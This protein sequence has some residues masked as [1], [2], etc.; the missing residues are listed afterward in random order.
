MPRDERYDG[1]TVCYYGLEGS[2][3]YEINTILDEIYMYYVSSWSS[4]V[5]SKHF[6]MAYMPLDTIRTTK[7]IQTN[8]EIY[9]CDP[10]GDEYCT[11]GHCDGPWSAAKA[12]EYDFVDSTYT[13]DVTYNY[14]TY[15]NLSNVIFDITDDFLPDNPSTIELRYYNDGAAEFGL[16]CILDSFGASPMNWVFHYIYTEK[17]GEGAGA[18]IEHSIVFP[19]IGTYPWHLIPNI[20]DADGEALYAKG[21]FR[22]FKETRTKIRESI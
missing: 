9:D 19:Y 15:V 16:T 2:F 21:T 13:T 20:T 6:F 1:D 14:K 3:P 10:Y 7:T 11:D 12:R 8:S 22:L 5:N 4:A 17:M 18:S